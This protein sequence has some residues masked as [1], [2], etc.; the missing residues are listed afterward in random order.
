[1]RRRCCVGSLRGCP[2]LVTESLLGKCRASTPMST[3]GSLRWSSEVRTVPC[4]TASASDGLV[5]DGCECGSPRVTSIPLLRQRSRSRSSFRTKARTRNHLLA[6]GWVVDCCRTSRFSAGL[7]TGLVSCRYERFRRSTCR[8]R[9]A[10]DVCQ[11][12][13][14]TRRVGHA[15][16]PDRESEEE[17]MQ[18]DGKGELLRVQRDA[19]ALYR[20]RRRARRALTIVGT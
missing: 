19:V 9:L 13:A 15:Q 16:I 4:E 3:R 6:R 12:E 2:G 7:P 18:T 20:G 11:W 1:M 5:V 8:P 14:L 17:M 10:A